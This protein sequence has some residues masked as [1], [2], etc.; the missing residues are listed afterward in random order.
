MPESNAT[1]KP[2]SSAATKN[3]MLITYWLV[4]IGLVM[5]I[6]LALMGRHAWCP[7]ADYILWSWNI[8]T[9]HCSQHFVDPYSL[10]HFQ[11]GLG[12]FL[13]L[14]VCL[15]KRISLVANIATV[16]AIEAC[17]ELAEN[18]SFI[19]NR[20][21]EATVSLDYYGDSITNSLGDYA[22]CLLGAYVAH[23]LPRRW[24]VGLFMAAEIVS[25]IWIK[26]SLLINILMLIAPIDSIKQ[27]Q[28]PVQ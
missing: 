25:L 26:D 17:W 27:W 3:A 22:F 6:G 18:T 2:P 10:S 20:Y 23:Q 14:N 1:T 16:A 28:M 8:W 24:V 15:G 7:Q 9:A 11:H 4:G 19:I 5:T 12:L 21:R 13:L